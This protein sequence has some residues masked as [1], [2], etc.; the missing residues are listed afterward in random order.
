MK[1]TQRI[2]GQSLPRSLVRARTAHSFACPALLTSLARSAALIHSLA[3]LTHLLRSSLERG[4]CLRIKCVDFIV[5][6]PTVHNHQNPRAFGRLISLIY[7]IEQLGS[8][9]SEETAS[10]WLVPLTADEP[11]L[12]EGIFQCMEKCEAE[13]LLPVRMPGDDIMNL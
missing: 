8:L 4:F 10:L 5:F 9:R 11:N 1:S 13:L 6:L 2:Q 7:V 12:V 3:P